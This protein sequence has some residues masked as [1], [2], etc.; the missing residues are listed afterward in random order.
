MGCLS[1]SPTRRGPWQ[2]GQ[3]TSTSTLLRQYFPKEPTCLAGAPWSFAAS[4]CEQQREAPRLAHSS[5]SSRHYARPNKPLLRRRLN[6]ASLVEFVRALSDAWLFVIVGRVGA[7]VDI[8]AIGIVLHLA[9]EERFQSKRRCTERAPFGDHQWM[10]RPNTEAA[11]TRSGRFDSV[12]TR[13]HQPTCRSRLNERVNRTCTSHRAHAKRFPAAEAQ[14]RRGL[15]SH[16]SPRR[17]G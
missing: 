17:V 4:R 6:T 1:T 9:A 12:S 16:H 15:A 13:R 8:A 14:I 3:A 2:R 5:E 11:S 10:R 7:C